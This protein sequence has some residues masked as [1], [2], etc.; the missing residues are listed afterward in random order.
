MSNPPLKV[1]LPE[2]C[3]E[4][5]VLETT[6]APVPL[7]TPVK[8]WLVAVVLLMVNVPAPSVTEPTPASPL[9]VPL[10]P[11]KSN[12]LPAFMVTTEPT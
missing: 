1:L 2:I 4:T 7:I 8:F 9:T 11:F 3:W 6:T 10:K 5:P 12:V